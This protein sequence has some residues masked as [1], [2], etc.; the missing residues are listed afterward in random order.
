MHVSGA[1]ARKMIAIVAAAVA[2]IIGAA[3]ARADP[4]VDF[5]RGKVVTIVIGY[6]AGGFDL[7]ARLLGR[8]L[9]NH[10]PGH[11]TIIAQNRPGAG[12]RAAAN[13]LY[14]IAPRDGTVIATL[15]QTTPV[16]QALAQPDIKFDARKFNWIGNIVLANNVLL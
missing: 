5:Y 6:A 9:G 16:D 3:S 4:V 14:N 8:F 15:S 11:P 2:I 13:W 12:S 10:I 1:L 7:Y